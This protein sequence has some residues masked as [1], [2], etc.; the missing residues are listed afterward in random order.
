M[1]NHMP[2]TTD[3]TLIKSFL[4]TVGGAVTSFRYKHYKDKLDITRK[5]INEITILYDNFEGN[6][7]FGIDQDIGSDINVQKQTRKFFPMLFVGLNKCFAK[8]GGKVCFF[9]GIRSHLGSAV[10]FEYAGSIPSLP[11]IS[12]ATQTGVIQLRL[13]S[14]ARATILRQR[15]NSYFQKIYRWG[16]RKSTASYA[17]SMFY[18][19]IVRFLFGH[20]NDIPK[21]YSEFLITEFLR[22]TERLGPFMLEQQTALPFRVELPHH[23]PHR[24]ISKS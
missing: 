20:T 11:A 16:L 8:P 14:A 13:D 24:N 4:Y 5:D 7:S 1:M 15:S 21:H 10:Q 2:V 6:L 18:P 22:V 9:L 19:L 3:E 17:H 23:I 12:K